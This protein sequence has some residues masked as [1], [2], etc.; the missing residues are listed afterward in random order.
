MTLNIIERRAR[1]K[2]IIKQFN[3]DYANKK[4]SPFDESGS[5]L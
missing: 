5:E 4:T 2:H 1:L 3:L